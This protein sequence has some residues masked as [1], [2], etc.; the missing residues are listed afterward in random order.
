MSNVNVPPIRP[1]NSTDRGGSQWAALAASSWL[2]GGLLTW[3]FYRAIPHAGEHR[4]FL[5]RYFCSHPIEYAQALLFFVGGAIL[6]SK[7]IQLL[8]E[9]QLVAMPLPA[10]P[11]NMQT[12]ACAQ[13]L[14]HALGQLPTRLQRT[15]YGRRLSDLADYLQHR[16]DGEGLEAHAQQLTDQALDRQHESYGQLQ[17]IIWAVP[18][19]GFLG[20][21]MGITLAIASVTPE[22]LDTSL[23]SVTG[24]LAVAFDTTSTAL[25]QSV[26]LVFTSFFIKRQESRILSDLDEKVF[27]GLVS[28]LAGAAQQSSPIVEAESRA[29][30]TLLTRTESL[31]TQQ[32]DLWQQSIESLRSRWTATLDV[33]QQELTMALAGGV[34][35]SLSDHAQLLR[36]LREEFV[37]A[38]REISDE[39]DRQRTA[40]REHLTAEHEQLRLAW[41]AA[42][43]EMR[44]EL[45]QERSERAAAGQAL[46]AGFS[47]QVQATVDQLAETTRAVDTQLDAISHQTELL[48]QLAGAEER[49]AGLQARLSDN[50]ETLQAAETLEQTLH[51]LNAAIHLLT[52][53]TRP[54]AA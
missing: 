5:E 28:P 27:K 45:Q 51:S 9:R 26:L 44:S 39:S 36:G 11:A 8:T 13:S 4:A 50:L 37:A 49:L 31:I 6:V 10:L 20:T 16:R 43:A 18:I 21:V 2:W 1:E 46:L 40:S 22:Q 17:T 32:T 30:Q 53:R 52:A 34:E 47:E 29:A 33:Q 23:N 3:G 25:T 38:Y 41:R 35:A 48:A 42:W 15:A 24:G 7:A 12:A 54:V 14:R 19:L